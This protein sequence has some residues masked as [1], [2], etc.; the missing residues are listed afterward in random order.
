[1]GQ[2]GSASMQQVPALAARSTQQPPGRPAQAPSGP[3]QMPGT[4]QYP[5]PAQLPMTH[6]APAGQQAPAVAAAWHGSPAADGGGGAWYYQ[7]DTSGVA[8]N[9]AYAG[10]ATQYAPPPAPTAPAAPT[11]PTAPTAPQPQPA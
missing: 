5:G 2:R 3:Q 7:P 6:Q 8:Q 11:A 10:G 1:A 9:G 4:Q